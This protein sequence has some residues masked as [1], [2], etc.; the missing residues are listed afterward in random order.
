MPDSAQRFQ[1]VADRGDAGRRLDQ[2]L[3]RRV[4]GLSRLSRTT[5]QRWI[6]SGAV[7]VDGRRTTRAAATL[8]EGATVAVMVPASAPRRTRPAAE[9]AT[10][11]VLYEDDDLIVVNKPAGIVVHP[12]YK[13][14]AGTVL[15]GLLWHLRD[16][17]GVTPGI[18]TRLDKDTSGLVAIALSP[19]IHA[20]MQRDAAAGRVRKEYLAIVT[21]V[22]DPRA[23]RI[24]FALA[25]DPADRRRV[26][27]TPAGAKS[28]TRYQVLASSLAASLV[29][30]ELVTGRTHQIRV[31]LSASG[32][33]IA[34]DRLYGGAPGP[35]GRQALHAWRITMPH[36]A[37]R[38]PLSVEA[39]LP[40]DLAATLR[41]AG[42]DL[43]EPT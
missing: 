12:T 36:P 43:P 40:A 41:D 7:E 1:F 31:H 20:T 30:C 37:T 11:D 42:L 27:A 16:R 28:E 15:N 38:A 6:E 14:T 25:R 29:S 33:P 19:G 21:T 17:A 5:A 24:T 26:V 32:W 8:R 35:I 2:A 23:G 22:P 4:E 34:G 13:Q 9:P 3:V 39:P 10:L 18:L